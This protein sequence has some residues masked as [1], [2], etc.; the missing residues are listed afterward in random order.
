[1]TS[2]HISDEDLEQYCLG[3]SPFWRLPRLEEHILLCPHCQDRCEDM[4]TYVDT[5]RHALREDHP[6]LQ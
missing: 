6:T 3:H 4:Q 2:G 5:I 1:M